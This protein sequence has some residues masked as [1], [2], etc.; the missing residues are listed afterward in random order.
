M[1]PALHAEWTKLRT[2][3]GVLALLL[4]LVAGTVGLSAA[5]C[6]GPADGADLPRLSLTGI[7]LG[8]A[9]VAVF[10]AL[11]M[12]NEYSIRMAGLTFTAMPRRSRV[13]AAKSLILAAPCAVAAALAVAGCLAIERIL[14]PD[15]ETHLR[16]AAGSV[17]YLVLIGL[18]SLGIAAAVRDAAAATGIVLALQYATPIAI[19]AVSDPTWQK[20]LQQIAPTTAGLAVQ[21]TTGDPDIGPW[22]GLAVLALWAAASLLAG[23]ALLTRRDS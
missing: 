22:E 23:A 13:L 18:L 20:H 14:L 16:P 10:A 9:V 6:A 3:P 15:H 17:L 8:Q 1:R 2:M 7:Q 21:S 11:V 19:A 5:V 12:G 4:A